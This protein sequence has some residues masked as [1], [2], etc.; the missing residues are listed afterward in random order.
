MFGCLHTECEHPAGTSEKKTL[1]GR[2]R[3]FRQRGIFVTF[4]LNR[5]ENKIKEV[6]P[7]YLPNVNIRWEKTGMI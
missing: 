5:I 7:P 1:S 4:C 6:F 3:T 2:K